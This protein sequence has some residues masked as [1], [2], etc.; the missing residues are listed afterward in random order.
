MY[1]AWFNY[2]FE[3]SQTSVHCPWLSVRIRSKCFNRLGPRN[4]NVLRLVQLWF[5]LSKKKTTF[6]QGCTASGYRFESGQSVRTEK[7][8]WFTPASKL[9][10]NMR[11]GLNRK[12]LNVLPLVQLSLNLTKKTNCGVVISQ[13]PVEAFE[14]KNQPSSSPASKLVKTIETGLQWEIWRYCAWFNHQL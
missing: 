5:E 12:N 3:F 1:G 4:L 13:N 9:V 11:S 6:E 14:P 7:S 2:Q 8:A 10:K